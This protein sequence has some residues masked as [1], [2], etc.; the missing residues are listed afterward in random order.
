MRRIL[1]SSLLGSA[2]L[3]VLGTASAAQSEGPAVPLY[4][5]LGDH[6]YAITTE[7]PLAQ[8]YFDQGLRLY[9]AFNHAEAIRAFEQGTRLDPDCA[10]CYWGIALSY[11]PNINA[12]MD[13]ASGVAAYAAVREAVARDAAASP[14]ERA[15]IGA[16]AARYA[17]VP[18]AERAAL[19][20]AYAHAM[21]A[22]VRSFPDDPE[23]ATL[24]AESLMDLS[25]WNYW[26]VDG[27]P[28]PDTGELLAQLERVTAAYPDH[29]GANH[30][31]IHAVEPVDPERALGAAERLAGLMPGAGHL[32]HM[33][34]HIYVRVGRYRDVIRINQHAVHA[35]ETYIRDQNPAVGIY[36]AG[37]YPHNYDFLAFAASMIG[38]SEQAIAAAEKMVEI[39]PEDMLRV[40]GL[41][42]LQ[43]HL[44]RHLQLEVRFA[45]WDAILAEPAPA[46][47]LPHARA[48]WHY[49]RGRALAARGDLVAAEAERARVRATAEDPDVAPLRME[50]NTSGAVLG[51][52]AEVLAG[53][54]AAARGDLT[55]AI[56]HLRDGAERERNL[57]YGEPPEWTVPVRHELGA[58][59]LAADRPTE[60]EEVFRAALR[61]FPA[62][63]WC[64][65]GL[66]EALRAQ[67]R[68][69]EADSVAA[70]FQE[71][72][73]T[74]DVGVPTYGR[75]AAAP[76][77]AR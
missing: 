58:L 7:V 60:A 37:Y 1:S 77:G 9:Y 25:P 39:V 54:I 14:V 34:G 73:A 62:N 74:A 16:L 3:W 21:A 38:H 15:L 32:V 57:F 22:V 44:T 47:D 75:A 12:P 67:G 48:M 24:Y 72:W 41:T 56:A 29:P 43:N 50:F 18:P 55:T 8:R 45:R 33:P 76:A 63:G 10:M 61:R 11:G 66:A 27:E 64:L 2:L 52:A 51:I 42:F 17:P 69:A 6:H 53:H 13:S 28:R 70:E 71:V 4:D 20:S 36:V 19:D 46:E 35:D 26:T 49:A 31:Y 23:A 59:L 5:N 65:A 30:F 40:P 68:T